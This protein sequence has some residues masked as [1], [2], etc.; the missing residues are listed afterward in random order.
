[1]TPASDPKPIR[2]PLP[3]REVL[4]DLLRVP[5][6]PDKKRRGGKGKGETTGR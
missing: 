3:E 6:P 2:L 5:P 4:A 1:M